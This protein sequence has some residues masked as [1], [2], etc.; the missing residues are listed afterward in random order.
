MNALVS[1]LYVITI[2][3]ILLANQKGIILIASA[4]SLD[5]NLSKSFIIVIV[6]ILMFVVLDLFLN[7]IK[8]HD[9]VYHFLFI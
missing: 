8:P 2:A 1:R 5:L 7:E 6:V 3:E 9:F 4:F